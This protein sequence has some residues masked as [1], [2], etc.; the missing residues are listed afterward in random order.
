VTPLLKKQTTLTTQKIMC[1]TYGKGKKKIQKKVEKKM[2][3]N[4]RI[5]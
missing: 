1:P 3:P 2:Q 4:I 5:A